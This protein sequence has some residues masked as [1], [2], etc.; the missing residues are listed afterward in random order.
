MADFITKSLYEKI[1]L[2]ETYKNALTAGWT[3]GV[4]IPIIMEDEKA[5]VKNVI[6]GLDREKLR[7]FLLKTL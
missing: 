3:N 6:S 2:K 5:V 7:L 4:K 1:N